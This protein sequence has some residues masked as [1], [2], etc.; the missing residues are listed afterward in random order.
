MAKPISIE[1]TGDAKKF[2][3]AAGEVDGELS[4]LGRSSQR[5]GRLFAVGGAAMAAGIGAGAAALFSIGGQF[6]EM[7]N[8]IIQGTGA[9]GEALEGLTDSMKNVLEG[10]PESGAVVAGAL[11]DVNTF[12][13]ATGDDLE[14]MTDNF[15][16]FSRVTGTDVGSAIGQVDAA[17]TQFGLSAGDADEAMGDFLRISQATGAP[18]DQLLGQMETF[19][20]LFA[21]AGFSLEETTAI[22]GQLET[23]GVNVTRVGPALNKFFRDA[24]DA[25]EDPRESLM[26]VQ[27][28]MLAAGTEAEALNIATDAFG[29]E[30]AQRMTSAI[31]NGS[32]DLE[33]LNELMGEGAGL[34]GDQAEATE[35]FSDKWNTFKNKVLVKLEPL[36]T[37]L[38][39]KLTEG[40]EWIETNGIPTVEKIV[41]K[42]REFSDW[43]RDNSELVTAALIGIGGVIATILVAAFVS[44]AI[45]AGA[46]AIATLAAMAPIIAV[47]VAVGALAV[48]IWKLWKDW[49]KIWAGIKKVT[50]QVVDW[51]KDK[52][53]AGWAAV[54]G[55]F[56]DLKDK[57]LAKFQELKDGVVGK[58]QALVTEVKNWIGGL[59]QKIKEL[60]S[61]FLEAGKSLGGR[62]IAGLKNGITGTLGFVSDIAATLK[63][64]LKNAINIAIIDKVNRG[65]R[66]AADLFNAIPLVPDMTAPQIPR[67]F[68]GTDS[69]G[70]GLAVVGEMGREL[71]QLPTGSK[72]LNNRDTE[73]AL[74]GSTSTTVNMTVNSNA[75]HHEI[76]RELAWTLRTTGR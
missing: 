32:V 11:A 72:V 26:A 28:A 12:F 18:M 38:F 47:G 50:G 8:I 60:G 21:N 2:K 44:W 76:A 45:A 30:G 29:A 55:F 40:M 52:I 36:A 4:K 17:L 22:F 70:G 9:S 65:L 68:K 13:G 15:L 56:G 35:T 69:F 19:G 49:D 31:R 64:A 34:V 75:D 62:I 14:G 37:K 46:A 42:F 58:A 6:D 57:A 43:I 16:D 10:V 48:L 67:L 74:R 73:A 25:G 41:A 39:D 63:T 59:P 3:K 5:M 20:P 7:E 71:I 61:D 51:V 53:S 66:N 24:A 33:N 1:I 27:E 54:K 23:A